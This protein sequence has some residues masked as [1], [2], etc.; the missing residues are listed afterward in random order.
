MIAQVAFF[1][2]IA[3]VIVHRLYFS[4]EY[5]ELKFLLNETEELIQKL[6]DEGKKQGINLE[7]I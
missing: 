5:R 7:D 4:W 3:G 6:R 2:F 1:S